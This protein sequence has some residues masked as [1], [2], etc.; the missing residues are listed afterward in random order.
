MKIADI[1]L[2][3]IFIVLVIIWYFVWNIDSQIDKLSWDIDSINNT[4]NQWELTE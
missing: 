1:L 4:L 2:T 3:L